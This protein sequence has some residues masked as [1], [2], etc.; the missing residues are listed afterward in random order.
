MFGLDP[1]KTINS[2]K[3]IPYYFQNLILLKKQQNKSMQ[4]FPFGL[5]YPCLDDRFSN[6]GE[7]KGHYFYQDLLVA[8]RVHQNNPKLHIDVGSKVNGFVAH[9]ASFRKIKVL[10]IRPL[11]NK[12]LNVE[13]VQADL[14]S[15]LDNKLHEC[16]D[17][18]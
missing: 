17:S 7:A 13:F 3:G 4:K 15:P 12:I 6:S 10:D 11:S 1:I 9:V 5:S 18:L 14:M 8:S 16:C 2:I